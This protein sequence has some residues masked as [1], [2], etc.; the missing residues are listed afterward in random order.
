MTTTDVPQASTAPTFGLQG[1][2]RHGAGPCGA[3][4]TR[5]Y[6]CGP[7]CAAHTPA[8]LAGRPE[9][10][11]GYCAPARCYCGTCPAAEPTTDTPSSADPASEHREA[12]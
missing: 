3:T 1:P 8:A 5:P 6:P 10:S 7:R 4:P 11:G 9:P 12:A 2:C